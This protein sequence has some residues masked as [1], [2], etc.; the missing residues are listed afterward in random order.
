MKYF[1]KNFR[2]SGTKVCYY[3]ERL[4]RNH[5]FAGWPTDRIHIVAILALISFRSS[6]G[7]MAMVSALSFTKNEETINSETRHLVL[8]YAISV[9]G[10]LGFY[11]LC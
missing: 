3:F 2:T 7:C 4:V 11:Q 6:L 5:I 1:G 10:T 9:F 8:N